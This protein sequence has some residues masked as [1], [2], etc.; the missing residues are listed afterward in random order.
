MRDLKADGAGTRGNA[1]RPAADG[2]PPS[3]Q[4]AA[5]WDGFAQA[6]EDPKI[7]TYD[8][9][10]N[11]ILRTFELDGANGLGDF[12]N[13]A[14]KKAIKELLELTDPRE[15]RKTIKSLEK[16]KLFFDARARTGLQCAGMLL[17]TYITAREQYEAEVA[18]R[19]A[20]GQQAPTEAERKQEIERIV[21]EK[22]AE[23]E[24][25][26]S[27][28]EM[29]QVLTG[30]DRQ[31]IRETVEEASRRLRQD[32]SLS[33]ITD[34]VIGISKKYFTLDNIV[35]VGVIALPLVTWQYRWALAAV[36]G[37]YVSRMAVYHGY[38]A[39]EARYQGDK[40]MAREESVQ[41]LAALKAAGGNALAI[42]ISP[43]VGKLP[44]AVAGIAGFGVT[45]VYNTSIEVWQKLLRKEEEKADEK[46]KGF[47]HRIKSFFKDNQDTLASLAVGAVKDEMPG[48]AAKTV[49]GASKRVR[50]S[51]I[52]AIG[53]GLWM[54]GGALTRRFNYEASK[55]L[56]LR[57][58]EINVSPV[59]QVFIK[60]AAPVGEEA[61][62]PAPENAMREPSGKAPVPGG[63]S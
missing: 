56:G 4:A 5:W 16:N 45:Y 63:L 55:M 33:K 48:E 25:A 42:G 50:L 54:V 14:Q 51:K 32:S 37:A 10:K 19:V 62:A 8:Y 3:Q 36:M 44:A 20:Q 27:I 47:F 13:K 35:N 15:L 2:P 22:L 41:M 46:P 31:E 58:M 40:D 60:A 11:S 29:A 1:E 59:Q 53:T 38:K 39:V 9:L 61:K 12:L 34:D 43:L 24:V 18:K 17:E 28:G 49:E 30:K 23:P 6:V 7:S 21:G 52:T 26:E 57:Q